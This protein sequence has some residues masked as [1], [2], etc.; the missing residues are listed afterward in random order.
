MTSPARP[1][2]RTEPSALVIVIASISVVLPYF[3]VVLLLSGGYLIATGDELGW[4]IVASGVAAIVLDILIDV[5]WAVP[6][7]SIS[8]EP[9][10]NRPAHELVGRAGIVVEEIRFGRGKIRID[11][12][13]WLAEGPDADAGE[14]VTVVACRDVVLVVERR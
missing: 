3:G 13:L 1:P 9:N 11:Q 6:A 4:M 8:D 5:V 14:S 2:P 10:L 12:T 7:L